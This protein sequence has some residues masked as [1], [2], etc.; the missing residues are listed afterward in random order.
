MTVVACDSMQ[1]TWYASIWAISS[2][3]VRYSSFM[4]HQIDS[5]IVLIAK[6]RRRKTD[7]KHTQGR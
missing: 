3:L 5:L 4:N 7:R 6:T 2:G 1:S